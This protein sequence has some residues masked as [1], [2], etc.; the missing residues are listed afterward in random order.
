MQENKMG[1]MPINK[2][3]IT[4][5]LPIMIS[6]LIQALY[7]IVDSMFVAQINED[8][9]TAVSLA[10]P[11]QNLMIAVS[12]GT[13]VGINA[14]LARN[15][16]QKNREGASKAASNGIFLAILSCLVFVLF[17]IFGTRAFFDMQN[18]GEQISEYGT[19]YLS[20]CTIFSIGIF[21]QITFERILQATG[22]TFYTMLTQGSGAI[23]NIILDPILIF[24]LLGLPAMGVA[25][26]AL[27]TVIGQIVAT[28]LSFYFNHKVNHDIDLQIRNFRPSLTTI[29][30]IY[31][32]GFP[33]IIMASISSLMTYG[34][35]QIL[36]GFTKTSAAF[37]GVYIK[38]QSFIFMPIFGLNNGL[39]PIISFNY[40]AL[41]KKR[42]MDT[43]RLGIIYAVGIMCIGLALFELFPQFLLSF[44]NPSK[45][46]LTIGV[47]GLRIIAIHFLLAGASIVLSTTFQALN[48]GTCSLIVSVARQLVVLLPVAYVMSLTGNVDLVWLAYPIAEL[49]S[50]LLSIYFFYRIYQNQIRYIPEHQE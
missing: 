15:L 5:S 6:M 22:R 42:I 43:I 12:T 35:N 4:M 44:F 29:K 32:V 28:L 3:L 16:G 47:S 38:L 30:N 21:L 25:G 31:K 36:M 23:I 26:A 49:V 18:A 11:M 17:G 27:A 9:L 19:Q 50:L 40:G 14:L 41:K 37:F 34:M 10:F 20:I 33:S 48:H 13:G 8:A 45:Q 46:M 1:V 24:G 39:V 2:L 7:N